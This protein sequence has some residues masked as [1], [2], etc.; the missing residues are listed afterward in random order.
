MFSSGS[1]AIREPNAAPATAVSRKVSPPASGRSRASAPTRFPGDKLTFSTLCSE[2]CAPVAPLGRGPEPR[3]DAKASRVYDTRFCGS[4]ASGPIPFPGAESIF[5]ATCGAICRRMRPMNAPNRTAA[6]AKRLAKR[7][8]I[9]STSLRRGER[10]RRSSADPS[11]ASR[12][13]FEPDKR[14]SP[15]V[16]V[17]ETNIEQIGA[18]GKRKDAFAVRDRSS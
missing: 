14:R 5:S 13:R 11:G 10:T 6:T 8:I 9:R 7:T 4:Q 3:S 15:A 1:G 2:K 17:V 18:L 12:M 16:G